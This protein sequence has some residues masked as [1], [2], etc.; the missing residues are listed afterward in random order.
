MLCSTVSESNLLADIAKIVDENKLI[1]CANDYTRKSVTDGLIALGYDA[2][3]CK[4]SWG[5]NVSFPPGTRSN[6]SRSFDLLTNL[7][8][9]LY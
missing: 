4:S 2:S 1:N 6:R 8:N 7:F 9:K 3:I 5:K